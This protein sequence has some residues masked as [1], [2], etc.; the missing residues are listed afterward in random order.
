MN[1]NGSRLPN[2]L[3]KAITSKSFASRVN[4]LFKQGA[5]VAAAK[6][7]GGFNT[8]LPWHQEPFRVRQQLLRVKENDQ[9][10]RRLAAGLGLTQFSA[11][12]ILT[13]EENTLE[14][15][16]KKLA[17]FI[18][19]SL[20]AGDVQSLDDDLI[21]YAS[22]ITAERIEHFSKDAALAILLRQ[23]DMIRTK[24][25]AAIG[26]EGENILK[27]TNIRLRR[28]PE[29][30][31]S[32]NSPLP[33]FWPEGFKVEGQELFSEFVKFCAEEVNHLPQSARPLSLEAFS[34]PPQVSYN[35]LQGS[36]RTISE[37]AEDFVKM[38]RSGNFPQSSPGA[39][40]AGI[41]ILT[42][43]EASGLSFDRFL[44]EL[45]PALAARIT[46]SLRLDL[47]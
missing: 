22:F 13:T 25:S 4:R 19:D 12:F 9:F 39:I 30:A 26:Q 5:L 3:F 11:E 33:T 18:A 36:D 32:K 1:F 2:L 21:S 44:S 46:T 8:L 27:V 40:E 38:S 43:L 7:E 42:E 24:F 37:R 23:L 31:L 47:R 41:E 10:R 45:P 6:I 35:M 15:F 14:P 16:L 34:C 28:L 20:R 17:R 29:R